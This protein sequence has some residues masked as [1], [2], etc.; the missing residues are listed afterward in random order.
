M[1]THD[2]AAELRQ[3]QCDLGLVAPELVNRLSDHQIIDCYITCSCC[4]EKQVNGDALVAA[5]RQA[6]NASEFFAV[7]NSV[8]KSN[9]RMQ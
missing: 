7:C 9:H 4:G 6:R 3:R 8:A 1:H 2:L 5:I